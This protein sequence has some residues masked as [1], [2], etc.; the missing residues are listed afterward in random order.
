VPKLK[1]LRAVPLVDVVTTGYKVYDDV[2]NNGEKPVHAVVA[3]G[4]DTLAR[5]AAGA[6]VVALAPEAAPALLVAGVGAAVVF[7]ATE[8][9]TALT[10]EGHWGANIQQHGVVNGIG[11]SFADAGSAFAH[12]NVEHFKK[13]SRTAT[14]VWHGVR[15]VF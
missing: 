7:E 1:F 13:V 11:H 6:G 4:A 8:A 12:E 15:R 9:A 14:G 3:N 5:V 10:R 2:R